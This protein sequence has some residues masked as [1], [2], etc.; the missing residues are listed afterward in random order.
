MEIIEFLTQ[1]LEPYHIE[2][3]EINDKGVVINISKNTYLIPLYQIHEYLDNT[4]KII[5]KPET[6][7]FYPGYY[8]HLLERTDPS[9]SVSYLA[10]RKR[11]FKL[12][13][14]DNELFLEISP[15]STSYLLYMLQ[16]K[17]IESR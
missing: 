4:E 14:Q 3:M 12:N 10:F 11:D 9:V 1:V 8:E 2:I 16:N 13:S 6:V 5:N 15:P 17:K 7:I